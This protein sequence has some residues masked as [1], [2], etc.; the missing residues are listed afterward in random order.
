MVTKT[1]DYSIADFLEALTDDDLEKKM[2]KLI[3][4]GHF[5]EDLLQRILEIVGDTKK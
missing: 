4:K 3:S 1:E 2:I 5:G